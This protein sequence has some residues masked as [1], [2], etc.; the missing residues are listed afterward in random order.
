MVLD[1]SEAGI[2]IV[3]SNYF[4]FEQEIPNIPMPLVLSFLRGSLLNIKK[5]PKIF[6]E[7]VFE[8]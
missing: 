5:A 6:K 1:Q 7:F 8:W 4:W 2:L 3:W